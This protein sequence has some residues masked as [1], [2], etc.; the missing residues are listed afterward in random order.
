VGLAHDDFGW[1]F[2]NYLK[3]QNS[4]WESWK[5]AANDCVWEQNKYRVAILAVDIDKDLN[6]PECINDR[7]YGKG[8]WMSPPGYDLE[9]K[10]DSVSCT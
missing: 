3:A 4:V 2:S 8:S 7:I 9:F 6:T 5:L 10:Y 1:R